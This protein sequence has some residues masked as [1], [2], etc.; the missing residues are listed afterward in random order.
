MYSGSSRVLIDCGPGIGPRVMR[1][2][3]DAEA[4]DAVYVTHQHADHSF[5]LPTLLL[6][7]RVSGR[8]KQLSLLGGPGSSHFLH[9]LLEL[10]YPGSFAA[11]RCFPIRIAEIDP[12]RSLGLADLVISTARTAHGVPCHAVR[13]DDGTF[14]LCFSGDGKPTPETISLFARTDLLVHECQSPGDDLV[15]HSCV[16]DVLGVVQQANPARVALVHRSRQLDTEIAKLAAELLGDRAWLPEPGE[17]YV[18]NL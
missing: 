9:N 8:K 14:S 16:A 4:F 15:D 11:K 7:L 17:D 13:I 6:T 1:A 2:C 5:G 12:A 10:G 3:H 18:W